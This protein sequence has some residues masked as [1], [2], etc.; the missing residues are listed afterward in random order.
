MKT[1]I[2]LYDD[3][4]NCIYWKRPNETQTYWTYNKNGK[5][6]TIKAI[7]SNGHVV[8]GCYEYDEKGNN[9]RFYSDDG[10]EKRGVYNDQGRLLE[11]SDTLGNIEVAKYDEL[12][13]P[14]YYKDAV[15]FEH[16]W[17]YEND[18]S[19]VKSSVNSEEWI[20]FSTIVE[21]VLYSALEYVYTDELNPDLVIKIKLHHNG[22]VKS[23]VKCN[24]KTQEIIYEE[25]REYPDD[26][27]CLAPMN[28]IL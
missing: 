22:L 20:K 21:G 16:W 7:F 4:E 13:R 5:C 8:K 10:Y 28:L 27:G 6:D 25:N 17:E 9:T 15:G 23:I 3:N 18:A 2:S 1:S 26:T 24:K 14:I 11:T 12:N 19:F